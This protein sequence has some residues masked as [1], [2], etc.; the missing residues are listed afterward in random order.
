M[1]KILRFLL[2]YKVIFLIQRFKQNFIDILVHSNLLFSIEKNK[3]NSLRKLRKE[4]KEC[5]I[6]GGGP[7]IKNQNLNLLKNKFT[8]VH[9]AFYLLRANYSFKPSL[10]VL[11]DPLP[12]EDNSIELNKIKDINIVVPLKLKKYIRNRDNVTYI[13]F[14]YTYI[15]SRETTKDE[16][17]KF[18]F[19]DNLLWKG[20][21]G[22]TVVYFSL[23]IAYFL[24]FKKI[25]LFGVDLSYKIPNSAKID[26]SIITSTESDENHLHKDWFGKG[27]RWHFPRQDRM[28]IALESAIKFLSEKGVK[29]Y[30]FSPV[31]KIEGAKNLDFN[32]FFY[33]K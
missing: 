16:S 15:D 30:N 2:P 9:N 31:S 33:E 26:G 5:F 29:V 10:Y 1:K 7:S 28:K 25:Y 11:E 32:K 12:A 8:I 27:K 3:I 4:H 14:D 24:G 6:I 20:F 19:S 13:N 18:K 17:L 23:Q 22:G 21:W